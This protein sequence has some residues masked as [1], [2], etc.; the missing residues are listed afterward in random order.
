MTRMRAVVVAATDVGRRRDHNE[1]HHAAWIPE[2]PAELDRRGI[3]LMVADGM[4]GS[5]AG[6]VASKLAADI[7]VQ[8]YGEAPGADPLA[9]LKAAVEAANGVVFQQSLADPT[10]SGMGTTCTA[11]A[12]RGR[13]AWVA[14]VGDSRAYMTHGRE[15]HLLTRDHTLVA[16]LIEQKELT[17]EEARTDLRRNVVLRSV[18]VGEEVEVDAMPIAGPLE[19]GD[20]ILLC[21]DGL[22]GLVSDEELGQAMQGADMTLACQDLVALANQRGG[23]DNI[24]VVMA[25]IESVGERA[26]RAPAMT[27]AA[28]GRPWIA[29]VLALL[30]L[31]VA[32][33]SVM[34][35]TG[36]PL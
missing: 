2:D 13:E 6:E 8:R 17:E 10:M 33:G 11:L 32:V 31:A 5:Q 7:V 9:E 24:T 27:G 18:G 1:D 35:L 20:T 29:I 30:G 3:L 34:W 15:L 21:S 22:H 4:G 19:P 14:H 26:P 16:H 36:R 12:F 25:R 23:P 28:T